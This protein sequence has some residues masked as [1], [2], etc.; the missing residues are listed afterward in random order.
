[1]NEAD[2]SKTA[3]QQH[4]N[5]HKL[6]GSRCQSCGALFLPPRPMCS[7]CFSQDMAWEELTL[8]G[9]LAAFTVVHIAPTAMLEAGYG[10][11]NPYCSGVVKLDQGP[12]ISAQILGVDVK[13]PERIK[14]GTPLKGEFLERGAGDAQKTYLVF[15]AGT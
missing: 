14:I 15:K 6:M 1:M 9:R 13:S 3:Y 2:F 10:R 8:Q 11:D 12:S 4:L 7:Q 5:E